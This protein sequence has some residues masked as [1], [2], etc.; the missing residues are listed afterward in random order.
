MLAI[1]IS[2]PVGYVLTQSWLAGFA[3]HVMLE[4]WFFAGSGLLA[5]II[6]LF[7]IGSQ[8]VKAARVNPID[9]LRNE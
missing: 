9:C 7:T 1:V 6:P 4:W 3:Y 8:T 2:M 5:L